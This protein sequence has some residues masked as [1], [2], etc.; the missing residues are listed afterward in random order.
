MSAEQELR[1]DLRTLVEDVQRFAFLSAATVVS[2][3]VQM[4]DS[5]LSGSDLPSPTGPDGL[6]AALL[7]GLRARPALTS[8]ETLVLPTA[9]PGSSSEGLLWIHNPTSAPLTNIDLEVT[10]LTCSG[11]A[12]IPL[13]AL[14]LSPRRTQT[15]VPSGRQQV[16][17]RVAVPVGQAVGIYHGLVIGSLAPSDPIVVRLEVAARSR[18]S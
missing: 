17:I 8:V 9:W 6:V 11:T 16:L 1:D 3:Y 12:L 7:D 2:R 4:V 18:T 10:Q 5:M 15:V 14:S 13:D